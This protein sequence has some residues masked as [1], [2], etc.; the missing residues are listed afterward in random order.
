MLDFA[1]QTH[2]LPLVAI[3]H[4]DGAL[5]AAVALAQ[6]SNVELLSTDLVAAA[7]RV[8]QPVGQG[9]ELVISCVAEDRIRV[10]GR[11]L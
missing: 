11:V 5:Q 2:V 1:E 3:L 8:G 7:E 10:V 6:V 9:L 4:D